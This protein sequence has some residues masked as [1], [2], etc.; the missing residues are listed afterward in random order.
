MPRESL[1]SAALRAPSKQP[2]LQHRDAVI[3]LRRKGYTWREV[4]QFLQERG[5]SADH[6]TLFRVFKGAE[7]MITT[8]TVPSATEYADALQ[9]VPLNDTQK[10]M[11]R[12]HYQSHNR[13]ITYTELAKAAGFG[14]HSVANL[15]YGQLGRD[16]G[17]AVGFGFIDSEER[18]G[19]KFYSSSLGMKNLYAEGDF[20]LV[21]HHELARAIEKLGLA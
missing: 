6:T 2:L 8:T 16:L 13:S 9:R 15:H 7:T 1:L 20:Q 18:P 4:S 11:L 12:A 10:A 5:V 21:M 3:V 19:E 17:E 14:S